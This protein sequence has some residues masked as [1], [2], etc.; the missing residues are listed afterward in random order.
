MRS[1]CRSRT[2]LKRKGLR[3]DFEIE[4]RFLS[5]FATPRKWRS[6]PDGACQFHL[7]SLSARILAAH[8][9]FC[10][11]YTEVGDYL[12]HTIAFVEVAPHGR[13]SFDD[14]PETRLGCLTIATEMSLR[15]DGC[16]RR[17]L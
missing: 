8:D 4:R 16:K 6:T 5:R 12:L 3:P 9:L 14:T 15:P 7:L 13:E 11:V 1:E 2:Y 10:Y 17:K